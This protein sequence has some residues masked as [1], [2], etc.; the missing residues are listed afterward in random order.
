[1][2]IRFFVSLFSACILATGCMSKA[3]PK[4]DAGASSPVRSQ[5]EIARFTKPNETHQQL[6]T[7]VGD[8]T[9]TVK[10]WMAP[11]TD[12]Q[13]M[14]GVTH[15][16]MIFGGRHLVQHVMGGSQEMPFE[17]KGITSYDVVRGEYASIWIDTISTGMM[18]SRGVWDPT[19]KSVRE[20]GTYSC[21]M[22]GDKERPTRSV[23]TFADAD[24]YSYDSFTNGPDGKE[25]KSMEIVY[26]RAPAGD[27]TKCSCSH[28]KKSCGC[29][30]GKKG[31]KGLGKKHKHKK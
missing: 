23:L 15:N 8:W 27:V 24:H 3:A 16:E 14:E 30:N 11:N 20:S 28:G 5:E 9:Y 29:K 19:T 1:M 17:G 10:W 31:K 22:T 2:T 7:L 25:F 18:V 6:A 12:A 26:T 13:E 21:P 4:P